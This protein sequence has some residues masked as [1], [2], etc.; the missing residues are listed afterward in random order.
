[1][2]NSGLLLTFEIVDTIPDYANAIKVGDTRVPPQFEC[3]VA[4][5]IVIPK[6]K[7]VAMAG[8]NHIDLRFPR[9]GLRTLLIAM[10]VI[11]FVACRCRF[12]TFNAVD[13]RHHWL[14]VNGVGFSAVG[15]YGRS[16]EYYDRAG[17]H[18]DFSAVFSFKTCPYYGKNWEWDREREE[19]GQ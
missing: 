17:L 14:S 18:H 8:G 5:Q 1:M 6:G 16:L 4:S 19:Y 9:F 15:I 3:R 7:H 12:E 13:G 2:N 10:V 11:G